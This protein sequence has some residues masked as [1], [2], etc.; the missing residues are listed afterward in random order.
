[1]PDDEKIEVD[2]TSYEFKE[3]VAIL[4]VD[5]GM[6]PVHARNK[7]RKEIAERMR[8]DMLKEQEKNEK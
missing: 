4:E 5:G 2:E 7:A 3:R 1:M 8:Y 6:H